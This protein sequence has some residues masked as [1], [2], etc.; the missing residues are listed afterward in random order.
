MSA[1][2][3]ADGRRTVELG[4]DTF[5]D[6][7]AHADGTEHTP[8]E[9]LRAIT[10]EAV[11]ADRVGLD[12]FGIGE[13]HR[14]D[15]AVSAPE[16]VLAAIGARTERI[17]LTS[18]VTVLSSDDPVRVYERFA[19]LQGLTGGRAE[20]IVGRGAYTESF[21][22]FGL[23]LE[24]YEELFE[25]RLDLFSRLLTGEPVTWEGS[26]R[27]PLS[28]QAVHPAIESRLPAWVAVGGSRE[29]IVRAARHGLPVVLAIIGGPPVRFAPYAELHRRALAEHGH[30]PQPLGVHSP[31]Y[32]AETDE[33][34]REEFWPHYSEVMNRLGR[35]RGFMPMSRERYEADAVGG[36]LMVG[37]PETVARRIAETLR[38]LGA[39]RFSMK[40]SSGH[41]P[42][43][44]AMTSI[45]L[46]GREVA[47]RVREL[48][49]EETGGGTAWPDDSPTSGSSASA[50]PAAHG[51]H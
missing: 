37:S 15:Y 28:A 47:P 17:H 22:L 8:A 10:E 34:A 2:A 41:M 44:L 40:Y 3:S 50:A 5:G 20:I 11:L 31:G 19:T 23:P 48:L 38:V 33:Q 9:T 39:S 30:V 45:D 13:H 29:S 46:Y 43:D 27:A 35:E 26:S 6:V 42:H 21:P 7:A 4:L 49:A 16:M 51:S 1:P 18:A 36:A 25:D 12:F 24:R 32:I 14:A